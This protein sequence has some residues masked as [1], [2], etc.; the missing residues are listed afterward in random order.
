MNTPLIER[1][2]SGS[3]MIVKTIGI[4]DVARPA[5]ANVSPGLVV[6]MTSTFALTRLA[7]RGPQ[8]KIAHGHP[9]LGEL[10]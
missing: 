6:T 9:C 1:S 2:P 7:A 3:G 5:A 4:D 8:Q 10:P